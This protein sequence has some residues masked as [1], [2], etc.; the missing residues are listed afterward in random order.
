VLAPLEIYTIGHSTHRAE[1]FLA[2]LA[3][4]RIAAVADIRTIPQSRRHPHFG[5]TALQGWLAAS[6]VDY[7]HFPALGG[8]RRPRKDSINTAVR[9]ASF[10]G[11]ADHMQTADFQEG[12][13]ALE[14]FAEARLTAVMCAEALWWQC[15][16]R[17]LADA[18]FVRNVKVRHI[19]SSAAA[20]PHELSAFAQVHDERVTYP[21]LV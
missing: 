15:H 16:R 8:L 19:M 20:N 10:R 11:Y 5:Q 2:L 21:G 12:V 3:A 9:H 7:M 6:G 17:F 14:A 13:A 4:H 18:L 1:A